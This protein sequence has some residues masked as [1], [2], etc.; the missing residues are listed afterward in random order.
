[1]LYSLFVADNNPTSL[2]HGQ[3]YELQWEQ[4]DRVLKLSL[5]LFMVILHIILKIWGQFIASV[6]MTL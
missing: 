1:M 3:C 5:E 4:M 6:A 2:E